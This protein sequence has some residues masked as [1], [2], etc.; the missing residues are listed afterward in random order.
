MA[1][2]TPALPLLLAALV[3]VDG[4]DT[5]TEV[6]EAS[7]TASPVVG[8]AE[9]AVGVHRQQSQLRRRRML[10][11]VSIRCPADAT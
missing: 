2:T 5:A 3:V 8:E 6:V 10:D 7:E 4:E 9:E 11:I 1:G